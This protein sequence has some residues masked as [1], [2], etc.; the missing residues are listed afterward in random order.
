MT[1]KKAFTSSAFL[2]I[3]FAA[4]F[5]IYQY[6]AGI[7]EA[8][9]QEEASPPSYSSPQPSMVIDVATSRVGEVIDV[10]LEL[11]QGPRSSKPVPLV[12][13]GDELRSFT[14]QT[15]PENRGLIELAGRLDNEM[16]VEVKACQTMM[17]SLGIS[18]D[19]LPDYV[20]V[21]PFGPDEV[22]RLRDGG[23][24]VYTIF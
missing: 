14:R 4:I 24:E 21:V 5:A 15:Y 17:N 18:R 2:L 10:L 16:K 9:E 8:S 3:V 6:R 23:Y 13:H 11:E 20:E 19:D 12:L 7:P 1:I 22:L